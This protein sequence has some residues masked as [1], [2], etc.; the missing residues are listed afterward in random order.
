M[1]SYPEWPA[2]STVVDK[3]GTKEWTATSNTSVNK[4]HVSATHSSNKQQQAIT[5]AETKLGRAVKAELRK[6]GK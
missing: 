6:Q 4:V 3:T 5:G 2:K 1:A